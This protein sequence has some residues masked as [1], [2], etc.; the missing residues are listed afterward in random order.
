MP[1]TPQQIAKA[2]KS[3]LDFHLKNKPIDQVGYDKPL[4]NLLQQGKQSFPGSRE[5]ITEQL[6]TSRGSNFQWYRGAAQV[7][8][9]SRDPLS[10]AKFAW[11]GV[12]DGFAMDEDEMLQNGIIL[13][14][15]G[16]AKASE[17]E[18]IQLSNLLEEKMFALDEGF[19]EKF[20]EALYLDGSQDPEAIPGLSALISLTPAVGTIGG[21]NRATAPWWRNYAR[22]GVVAANLSSELEVAMR[23]VKL[24]GAFQGI[25]LCGSAFLDAYREHCKDEIQ[26]HVIVSGGAVS[27]MDTGVEELYFRGVP[28]VWSPTMDRLNDVG[29]SWAKRGYLINK[30]HIKL[31]PAQGHDMLARTP[32][33]VYDRYVHYQ[34]VTWKG[35]VTINRSNGHGVIELA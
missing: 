3:A 24:N 31:R 13:T 11:S 5:Y 30:K 6:R 33:R 22:T 32:P 20:D 7:S 25:I 15:D 16:S 10:Q 1:F 28:L 35:G 18:K 34:A 4:L 14:D 29:A 26:R 19:K 21:I 8:Y 23:A 2:S 17:A 27:K 12:H 9:N